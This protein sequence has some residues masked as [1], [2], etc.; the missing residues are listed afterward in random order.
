MA[1]IRQVVAL[2]RP[3]RDHY[4]MKSGLERSS[5]ELESGLYSGCDLRAGLGDFMA[6]L[7]AN[8]YYSITANELR[9][10]DGC[11]ELDSLLDEL[12]ENL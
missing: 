5:D 2:P 11:G 7:I 6:D 8:F 9:G 12:E 1:A 4:P 3:A 10:R